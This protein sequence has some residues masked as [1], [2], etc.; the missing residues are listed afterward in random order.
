MKTWY[1]ESAENVLR[2]MG[3]SR[4]GLT[5]QQAEAV[6]KKAGENV[7]QEGTGNKAWQVFLEQ[8]QDLLVIILIAAAG[9]SMVSDNVES[10]VVIFAV[11]LMN[12]VLGTVQHEKARNSLDTLKALSSP[13]AKVIRNGQTLEF[14][15]GQVVPGDLIA[16]EEGDLAVADGRL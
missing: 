12:A 8:F 10:A 15:S 16:R 13:S 1:R 9:I 5:Q 11:I 3:S 2:D 6:R 14:P 7:L 4:S